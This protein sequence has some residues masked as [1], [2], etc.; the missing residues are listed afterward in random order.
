MKA[1]KILFVV[2]LLLSS[3]HAHPASKDDKAVSKARSRAET[4]EGNKRYYSGRGYGATIEEADRDAVYSLSKNINL[5]ALG[6]ATIEDTES[7][8]KYRNLGAISTYASI[9]NSQR[10]D[11]STEPGKA[12]VLRYVE[13]IDVENDMALRDEHIRSLTNQGLSMERRLEIGSA[14]KYFNW[15]YALSKSTLK[16]T[17]LDL[18]GE[19]YNAATW[20]D[21]HINTIFNTLQFELDGV[22]ETDDALDPYLLTMR[23]KYGDQPVGDLDFSYDNDGTIVDNQHVKNGMALLPLSNLPKGNLMLNINY[24]YASEGLG[25]NDEL[26]MIVNAGRMPRFQKSQILIPCKGTSIEK[27]KINQ[28]KMTKAEE[29]QAAEASQLAPAVAPVMIQRIEVDEM[30]GQLAQRCHGSLETLWQAICNRS[31]TNVKDLF[32]S[33][34]YELFLRMMRSGT[35]KKGANSPEF[36][37]EAAGDFIIGKS[38]PVSI[39]YR[40]GHRVLENIVC[41]FNQDGKIESVAYALTK[42]A[43]DDIFRQSD[44]ELPARYAILHFMEDYQTAYALKRHDY[45]SSIY[46]DDAVIIRG[47]RNAGVNVSMAGEGHNFL[48]NNY[49]YTTENKDQFLNTLQRQ[50]ANKSYIHLTFEDNEIRQTHGVFE[51]V[52]WIEI[53]QN[54][55]SSD[56]NDQGYLSLMIDMRKETPVIKVRT[57]A[58]DKIPLNELMERFTVQ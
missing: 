3:F 46:S 22:E 42:R 55:S 29:K 8:E 36:K 54:Y 50:F 32:T 57:W 19:S 48:V 2:A 49:T 35:V 9:P 39:T 53:K 25:Y 26:K 15:A 16:P 31:Y 5:V 11:I 10:I 1:T 40:G 47:K 17:F 44:W 43:E 37:I 18:Q 27:F 38:L 14:L 56:Y 13:V 58:P 21:G 34:G 41:R 23:V 45:I 20:L 4:I 24:Q 12:E 51:G 30:K 6:V 7:S 28:R 52:F 33:E